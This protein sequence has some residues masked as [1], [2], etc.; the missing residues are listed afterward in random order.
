[1]FIFSLV[2]LYLIINNIVSSELNFFEL[3]SK[4]SF[5]LYV[6][7]FLLYFLVYL[8]LIDYQVRILVPF[9]V[10]LPYLH[11]SRITAL[12]NITNTILP[13]RLGAVVRGTILKKQFDLKVT[14]YL[15]TYGAMTLIVL[16]INFLIG[17]VGSLASI[18]VVESIQ[19]SELFSP[20]II[21]SLGT[22]SVGFLIFVKIPDFLMQF[23]ILRSNKLLNKLFNVLEGLEKLKKNKNLMIYLVSSMTIYTILTAIIF[24]LLGKII[25]M[26]LNIYQSLIFS[27]VF[28]ITQMLSITPGSLGL[29]EGLL[30]LMQKVIGLSIPQLLFISLI[31]R[32]FFLVTLI[33]YGSIGE[34]ILRLKGDKKTKKH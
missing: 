30:I 20:L 15:S 25:S 19:P 12:A 34:I 26:E 5:G 31:D 16:F 1:M 23:L 28:Q 13:M 29:R 11:S 9:K 4:A 3:L 22:L 7:I 2:L 27:S 10:T 21:F 17:L 32:T 24:S 18:L 14:D 6:Q 8:V 33:L